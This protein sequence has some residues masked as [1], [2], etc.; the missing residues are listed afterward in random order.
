M[1]YARP[2]RREKGRAKPLPGQKLG[3][4]V[5]GDKLKGPKLLFIVLQLLYMSVQY[6]DCLQSVVQESRA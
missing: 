1:A 3:V 6:K 4:V 5:G 2:I